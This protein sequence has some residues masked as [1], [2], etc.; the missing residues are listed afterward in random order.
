MKPYQKVFIGMGMLLILL[1]AGLQLYLSFY[2]ENQLRETMIEEVNDAADNRYA[3][4]VSDVNLSI[5][6]R[7]LQLGGI[8]LKSPDEDSRQIDITIGSI[9]FSGLSVW[10]LLVTREL[11][12]RRVDVESPAIS[13]TGARS[14]NSG[15]GT[16]LNNLTPGAAAEI[17]TVLKRISIKEIALNSIEFAMKQSADENP[18]F[19][20]GDSDLIFYNA[21]LDRSAA[22]AER[23]MPIEDIEGTFRNSEFRAENGLYII[24]TEKIEFSSATDAASVEGLVLEPL[25]H[26]EEFFEE[27]GYRTDRVEVNALSADFNG[28]RFDKLMEIKVLEIEEVVLNK[29]DI[30]VFR[31][32]QFPQRENRSDRPLP[33]QMLQNLGIPVAVKTLLLEEGYIR[34]TEL[35]EFT[36]ERGTV[37]FTNLE[38]T[39]S[40]I[41]NIPV[42]IDENGDWVVEAE[43]D[44]MGKAGLSV[45][46]LLP[47]RGF[48]QSITGS[49][50]PMNAAELN[51]VLEPLALIRIDEGQIHSVDFEMELGENESTGEVKMIY[52]DLK[53][54]LLNED[55]MDENLRTNIGSFFANTFAIKSNNSEDDMRIGEVS[56]KRDPKKSF[57]NYWWKSLQSGLESS[58]SM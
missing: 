52:N 53:I 44:V 40:N 31:N 26:E 16:G 6:G 18:Y 33:Q 13:I 2:L 29:V 32:K 41:T 27:V 43:T 9:S 28:I 25:F 42:M 11:R 51:R 24:T 36:D 46:I 38:A 35:E 45:K 4:D 3:F 57:F 49:L 30:R 55:S 56:F 17:L 23:V 7:G 22:V 8:T 37:E 39:L 21:E 12:V 20:I 10:R 5:L 15:S 19:S 34:Y 50:E 54:S 1:Y 58:V 47:H 48:S 14:G